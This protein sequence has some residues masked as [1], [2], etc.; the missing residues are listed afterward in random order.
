MGNVSVSAYDLRP[1]DM[2]VYTGT[3]VYGAQQSHYKSH[4]PQRYRQCDSQGG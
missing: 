3:L 4:L 1:A 2:A